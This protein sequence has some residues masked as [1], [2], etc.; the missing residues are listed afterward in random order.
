MKRKCVCRRPLTIHHSGK[1]FFRGPIQLPAGF[2][3]IIDRLFKSGTQ[4]CDGFTVKADDVSDACNMSDKAAVVLTIVNVSSIT[5][6]LHDTR[7]PL[8][9]EN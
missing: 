6:M 5:L 9:I 1:G 3:V 7:R 2:K 4:F 8:P